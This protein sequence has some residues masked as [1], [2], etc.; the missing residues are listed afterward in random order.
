MHAMKQINTQKI[1]IISCLQNRVILPN[2][3]NAQVTR[4]VNGH[5]SLSIILAKCLGVNED[6]VNF[7]PLLRGMHEKVLQ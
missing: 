7:V 2:L 3:I 6:I 1:A 4:C 5:K